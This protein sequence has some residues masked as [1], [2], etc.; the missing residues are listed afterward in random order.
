MD[1]TFASF[2]MNIL[3]EKRCPELS[4]CKVQGCSKNLNFFETG[5]CYPLSGRD[6]EGRRIIL[7]QS[8]KW[9]P[10]LYCFYDL[11]R[12]FLFVCGVLVEEEETQI[13]GIIFILDHANVS[14][15]QMPPLVQIKDVIGFLNNSVGRNQGVYNLNLPSFANFVLE[16]SMAAMSMKLKKR[17]FVLKSLRELKKH[18]NPAL[19]PKE[20]GGTIT[21]AEMMEDFKKLRDEKIEI[22]MTIQQMKI[23]WNK[24]PLEKKWKAEPIGSF[25]KL[26]LD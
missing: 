26:E 1:Q 14:M 2:E 10:D 7:V 8:R 15:K 11:V 4:F 21:E 22:M 19:L 6:E 5:V 12:L 17:M 24:V 9:N 13:A 23:D 20:Y 18:I 16:T 25:R 3:Y